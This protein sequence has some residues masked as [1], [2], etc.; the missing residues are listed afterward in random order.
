MPPRG[1]DVKR[2]AV[3]AIVAPLLLLVI[4]GVTAGVFLPPLPAAEG[5]LGL[6]LLSAAIAA[7]MLL[8]L[9]VSM[10]ASGGPRIAVLFLVAAGVPANNLIEAVF[11]SL[12]IPRA[13]LLP[14]FLYTLASGAL[15]AMVLDW[16]VGAAAPATAGRATRTPANLGLRLVAVDVVYIALYLTAGHFV[17]PFVREFYSSRPLPTMPAVVA[18]Q[19]FRGLVFAAIVLALMRVLARR[20]WSAAWLVAAA[21]ALVGGVA[22]LLVPNPYMP[23]SVRF[24]H[25]VETSVSNF[26]F[27]LVGARLL[28]R[29]D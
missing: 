25:M 12:D 11:F 22:P 23:A 15:F 27:G 29:P 2:T 10:A 16:L 19:V 6:V 8:A 4:Q 13:N 24:P 3:V 7:W 9:A 14:L 26:L 28:R 18:M 5:G 21:M 1:G 17:W 20:P